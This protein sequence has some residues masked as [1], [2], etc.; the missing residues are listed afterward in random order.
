MFSLIFDEFLFLRIEVKAA[1]D[2]K[3]CFD[4][5]ASHFSLKTIYFSISIE[6]DDSEPTEKEFSLSDLIPE[7][8]YEIKVEEIQV[9]I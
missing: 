8:K 5:S 3:I 2:Y 4:N 6:S 9:A 1:G 7:E